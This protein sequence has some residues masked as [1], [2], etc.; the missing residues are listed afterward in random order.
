V[1]EDFFTS[2]QLHSKRFKS[3]YIA[4][5]LAFGAWLAGFLM[6]LDYPRPTP[7]GPRITSRQSL[8]V[9]ALRQ[10]CSQ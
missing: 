4:E 8:M 2:M 3:A 1:T 10:A 9:L 5:H 7:N 6:V